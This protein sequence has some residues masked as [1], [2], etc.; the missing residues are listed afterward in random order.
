MKERNS[1]TAQ[2]ASRLAVVARLSLHWPTWVVH[3][4]VHGAFNFLSKHTVLQVATE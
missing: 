3:Q 2:I 4:N 1:V